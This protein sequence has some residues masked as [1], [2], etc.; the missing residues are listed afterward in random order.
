MRAAIVV[1]AAVIGCGGP[2][3]RSPDDGGG[4]DENERRCTGKLLEACIDGSFQTIETCAN[5]CAPELGCV[6]C[7]PNTGVCEGSE[8]SHAC[9]PDGSGTVV[10]RCDPVQ[11][12]ACDAKTGLCEG[13]CA[14]RYLGKSYIGCEYYPVVTGNLVLESY[15][16][17]VAISNT[18]GNPATITI[19]DGALLEP[20][21]FHMEPDSVAVKTLPWVD[22]LKL[23]T[24]P[25]PRG[26]RVKRG[27]YR[28]RSTQPVTVYQFNPLNYTLGRGPEDF[29]WSN[30]ASLLAPTN[31]WYQN[32]VVPSARGRQVAVSHWP[33]LIAITPALD[34]T[35]ITV[36]TPTTGD[37]G[38]C[39]EP[40]WPCDPPGT[41]FEGGVPKT[42]MLNRGDVMQ[43]ASIRVT[44]FKHGFTNRDLSG[45]LISADKPLQVIGA[46]HATDIPYNYSEDPDDEVCC[47]DHL[48]E[49][50]LP[51]ETLSKEYLATAP[52]TP[53]MPN[54]R[55]QQIRIFA[56][57][58]NTTISY[59]PPNAAWPTTLAK[60]GDFLEFLHTGDLVIKGDKK[61]LVAQYMAGQ[62]AGGEMGDPALTV[63]VP[64]E[65]YRKDY[66]F[67]AP[68]NYEVNYANITA[69]IGAAVLLDGLP[70]TN[71]TPIG[72][73]GYAV[74]RVV[75]NSWPGGAHRAIS[76]SEFGVTV[77]GYGQH[78]SYW[79]PGG[80]DLDV[81]SVE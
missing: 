9:L 23:T 31:A 4:C 48:E 39:A 75:L 14:Q 11:G 60:A 66:L 55:P 51:I 57:A 79:Y 5:A 70:V 3:A 49:S 7:V 61:I 44:I 67:H 10:E 72:N 15:K 47:E 27:A 69:P 40:A 1:V 45:T 38:G 59:E 53:A 68:T 46:N 81:V 36:T 34:H 62:Q 56:T 64:V 28:L 16:F 43:I 21:V 35:M 6:V 71:L 22:A 20:I 8:I 54:G 30:D 65:Q 41:L 63:T 2:S 74:A 80:L 24:A 13:P 29:S 52:A 77:Y 78:T 73:S 18:T 37:G 32:F 42:V 25:G 12:T 76:T 33:S 26:A 17:A 19:E 50:V 58:D